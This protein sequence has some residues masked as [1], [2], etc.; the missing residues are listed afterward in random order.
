MKTIVENATSLSKYLLDDVEVVV[1]NDDSIVVGDPAKFIIADLN[2][3]NAAV[4]EGVTAPE[5]WTG[6]KYTFDG[7]EWVLNPDWVEPEAPAQ[8][9]QLQ[10]VE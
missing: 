8:P 9:Q 2:A 1:L 6:N 3:G 7:S 10:G 4:Y 5:G